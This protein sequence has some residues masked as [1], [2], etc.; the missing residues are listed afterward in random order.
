MQ[1]FWNAIGYKYLGQTKHVMEGGD[2]VI[3][4]NET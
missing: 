3:L 1:I 4:D 2:F